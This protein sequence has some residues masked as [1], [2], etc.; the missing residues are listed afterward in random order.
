[1]IKFHPDI[2]VAEAHRAAYALDCYLLALPNGDVQI[3][4]RGTK[5]PTHSNSNVVKMPKRKHQYMGAKPA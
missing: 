2:T 5:R 3:T 4:P 1:M